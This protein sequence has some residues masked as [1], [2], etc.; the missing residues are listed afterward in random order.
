[1][2]ITPSAAEFRSLFNRL[3]ILWLVAFGF[4]LVM[5]GLQLF[6]RY[7]VD[8]LIY[9]L[10]TATSIFVALE[11]GDMTVFHQDFLSFTYSKK[12]MFY[13]ITA[14]PISFLIGIK[15]ADY[16]SGYSIWAL[17]K[18]DPS[19]FFSFFLFA[20]LVTIVLF[21]VFEQHRF[22]RQSQKQ[23]LESHLAL[24]ASQLE[25]HMLFNTMANLRA[26]I[27]TDTKNALTMLDAL[28]SYLRVTLNG[29]R[30]SWHPLANEFARLDDYLTL[31][32]IRMGTRLKVTMD[33]PEHLSQ[34]PIPPM[35]LQPLVENAIKHGLEPAIAG[36]AL[37]IQAQQIGEQVLLTV[38]DTGVGGL[39]SEKLRAGK[40]FGLSQVR[41]R[42]SNIYCGRAQLSLGQKEGYASTLQISLPWLNSIG[43]PTI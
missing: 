43:E 29:S 23:L 33:C 20:L 30:V 8:A 13:I 26:L 42:L 28:N 15:L 24:L 5:A 1:M 16:C 25:P 3:L 38:S 40:G 37:H 27:E 19:R 35:L 34:L 39:C 2:F 31:M 12:R 32:S 14:T 11:T 7:F 21:V 22:S 17:S 41:D 9:S 36:G 6:P 4:A 18:N 10:V